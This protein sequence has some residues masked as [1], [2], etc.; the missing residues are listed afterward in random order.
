[1]LLSVSVIGVTVSVDRLFWEY[2]LESFGDI[3]E[4]DRRVGTRG[5]RSSAASTSSDHPNF[6][7]L[8]IVITNYACL[9]INTL[10]YISSP[11]IIASVRW[12]LRP[13]RGKLGGSFTF[14]GGPVLGSFSKGS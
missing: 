13:L 14:I 2:S 1:M 4:G 7:L 11:L 8:V 5:S 10:A 6:G 12:L 3:I 9:L